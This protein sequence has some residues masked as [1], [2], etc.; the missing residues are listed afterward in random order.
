MQ[1]FAIVVNKF[2]DRIGLSLLEI[3]VAMLI[4]SLVMYGMVSLFVVSKRF[5]YHSGSRVISMEL[6][7]SFFERESLSVT[8][9]HWETNK[10]CLYCATVCVDEPP[11]KYNGIEYNVTYYTANVTDSS[12]LDTT[13][14][15]VIINV[16]WQDPALK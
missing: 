7:K 13:L 5:V 2:R 11:I 16:T 6:G 1:R 14:R 9:D 10:N 3:I 12:S 15:K 4:L 8:A